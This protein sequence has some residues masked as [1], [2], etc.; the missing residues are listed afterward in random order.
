MDMKTPAAKWRDNGEQDPFSDRY[1]C[2]RSELAMG[3]M[4]DDEMAN[5][6]FMHGD[7]PLGGIAYL[8]AAKDRIRWLSRSL[9]QQIK[10]NTKLKNKAWHPLSSP[11]QESGRYTVHSS[12]GVRDAYFTTG[13][14][15]GDFR[16]QDCETG[17]D[18]GM[19]NMEGVVYKVF[20]WTYMPMPDTNGGE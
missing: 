11:P 18:E 10:L 19:Q 3:H 8:N 12:Y 9:H 1:D 13:L 6:V 7:M 14:T 20:S 16:W 17:N 2:E 4:T 5:A 15:Q